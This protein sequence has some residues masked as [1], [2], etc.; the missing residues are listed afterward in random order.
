MVELNDIPSAP[1]KVVFLVHFILTAWGVQGHWCPMSYL[2]YNLMF[3]MILLWAIHHKEGDEPMQMAVAVSALS[4]FLDVIVIS[5]YFPDSYRSERFSVGMAI[6][7]LIIRPVTT[8]VLY[9]IYVERASAAGAPLPTI[10]G[11]GATQRSPYED[12]DSAVHQSVP[13]TDIPSPSH[14]DPGNKMP[15]PYHS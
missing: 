3:F 5:M 7:N 4:I 12:I 9:R 15:P 8:L 10:F 11:V 2:F 1:I 14:Y 13:R 6:L